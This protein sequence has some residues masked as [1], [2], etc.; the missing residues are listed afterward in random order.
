M[1]KIKATISNRQFS[2]DI[3][4]QTLLSQ[5]MQKLDGQEVVLTLDKKRNTRSN[6]ENRYYYGVIIPIF[7]DYIGN[8]DNQSSDAHDHLK[9]QFLR[10]RVRDKIT[11][12]F[13]TYIKSTAELTSLEFENYCSQCR[14]YLNTEF[15]L[16]VPQPNE[17]LTD[18]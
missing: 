8:K 13:R 7:N 15:G 5:E 4:N 17:I 18:Y 6:A 1:Q 10:F 14:A 9:Y 3:Q 12:R 2:F 11:K 16:I